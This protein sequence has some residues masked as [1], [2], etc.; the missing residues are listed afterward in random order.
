MSADWSQRLPGGFE[1]L[2][3]FVE[4]WALAREAERTRKR[5]GSTMEEITRFYN[6]MIER[7]DP[8][9]DYLDTFDLDAMPERESRLFNL[10]LS[11]AEVANAVEYYH[12]PTSRF[13][14]SPDRFP[15]V[16]AG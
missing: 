9:L 11:L 15:L 6:A 1:D 5:C 2:E 3:P 8:V 16:E 13:A 10:A 4:D 12:R 14:M 7:I